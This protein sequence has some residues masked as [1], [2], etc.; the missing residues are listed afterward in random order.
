MSLALLFPGQ[1]SQRP[2]MLDA[3]PTSP[4]VETAVGESRRKLAEL[5]L[6]AD[7]DSAAALSSTVNCQ[8]ALLVS[9][10][11]CARALVADY[12]LTPQF[13]AGH[14]VGAFAAAVIAGVLTLPEALTTVELRGRAMEEACADGQWG[15]AA[16]TGLPA[17]EVA[18]ILERV[19][20]DN[21]PV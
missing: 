1:G 8:L 14:S 18:R 7:I 19:T 21:D 17:R 4:A 13:V 6:P 20:T 15:M 2:G 3:L 16:I 12:E 5:G 11:A 9:G 10:V